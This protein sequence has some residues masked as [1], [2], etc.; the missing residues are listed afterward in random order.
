MCCRVRVPNSGSASRNVRAH[1]GPMPLALCNR[2]SFSRHRGLARSV[3]SRSVSSVAMSALR[4]VIG[5]TLSFVRRALVP[6]R[7][8]CSAVRLPISGWRRPKR[9]RR[10][11]VWASGSGRGVGRI[12]SATWARA[13][14]STASVVAHWVRHG[15]ETPA[16]RGNSAHCAPHTICPTA[17][18]G[19]APQP[20]SCR[21]GDKNGSSAEYRGTQG[22]KKLTPRLHHWASI[23]MPNAPGERRPTGKN[24]RSPQKA[25]AVGRPFHW[26]DTY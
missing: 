9:A 12:T 20:H 4:H 14:A 7:R 13:R 21:D 22:G 2:S 23:P 6:A 24:A 11:C 10:S 19:A 16:M 17:R 5:A 18:G 25:C 8:F 1:T 15:K 26:V 3:V